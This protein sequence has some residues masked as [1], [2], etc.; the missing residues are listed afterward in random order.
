[1][2]ATTPPPPPSG[3]PHGPAPLQGPGPGAAQRPTEGQSGASFRALLEQL[4]QRADALEEKSRSELQPEDLPEAVD[5]AR[6][7]MQDA[8][9]LSTELLEAWRQSRHQSDGATPGSRQ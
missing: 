1:M 9:R 2:T 6:A 4:E 7:S 3:P 5:E 8:L